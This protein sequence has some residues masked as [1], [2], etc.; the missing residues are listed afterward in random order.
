VAMMSGTPG[1]VTGNTFGD[2]DC[3]SA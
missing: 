2:V 1:T 3:P